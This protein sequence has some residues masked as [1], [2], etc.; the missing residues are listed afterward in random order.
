MGLPDIL[1]MWGSV[2]RATSRP[3]VCGIV[4]DSRSTFR[5]MLLAAH[6][7]IS[8]VVD[9]GANIC[10]TS[11]LSLLVDVV[12]IPPLPTSLVVAG[13]DFTIDRCCT[14]RSLLP[15]MLADGSIHYQTCY[16]CKN[17]VET[18]VSPQA[19][20]YGSGIFVEWTQTGYKDDSPGLL[21]F[22]SASGLASMSNVL[23]KHDDLYYTH[24]DVYMVDKNLVCPMLYP[25]F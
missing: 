14:N 18:I 6:Q 12:Y 19:I 24:T 25:T 1:T 5:V 2:I 9:G 11:I 3:R 17:A 22:S 10:L 20:L 23:E 21:R 16:N 4:G 13:F 15:L 7:V 8:S